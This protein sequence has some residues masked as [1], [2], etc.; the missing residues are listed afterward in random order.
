MRTILFLNVLFMANVLFGAGVYRMFV[1]LEA[2]SLPRGIA[3]D[4]VDM[5]PLSAHPWGDDTLGMVHAEVAEPDVVL[6]GPGIPDPSDYCNTPG[7][8]TDWADHSPDSKIVTTAAGG[9]AALHAA[10]E[11]TAQSYTYVGNALI[12]EAYVREA[13]PQ[14]PGPFRLDNGKWISV[15]KIGP[16]TGVYFS[17]PAT[18]TTGWADQE[19]TR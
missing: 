10:G 18:G 2:A 9:V 16:E 4:G 19:K 11:S 14:G 12:W 7:S 17:G 6:E 1:P 13:L 8:V 15:E 3:A 5:L